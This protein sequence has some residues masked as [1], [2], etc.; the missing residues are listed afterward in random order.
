MRARL[1]LWPRKRREFLPDYS[2]LFPINFPGVLCLPAFQD[3]D[4]SKP[5]MPWE[6]SRLQRSK[7]LPLRDKDQRASLVPS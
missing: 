4:G 5:E 6:T 3:E 2:P 1:P 7:Q